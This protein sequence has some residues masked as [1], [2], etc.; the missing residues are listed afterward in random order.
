MS[1]PGSG[2]MG[3]VAR[4]FYVTELDIYETAREFIRRFGKNAI[5]EAAMQS[6]RMLDRGDYPAVARWNQVMR[7]IG[8]LQAS[9]GPR[10][11]D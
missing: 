4:C 10:N 9:P 1:F 7:A 6:D 3:L 8:E 2:T 5:V 11:R